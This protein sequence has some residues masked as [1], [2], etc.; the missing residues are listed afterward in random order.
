M[1]YECCWFFS[2]EFGSRS[3]HQY[4]QARQVSDYMGYVKSHFDTTGF[5]N[6]SFSS[7]NPNVISHMANLMVNAMG[8]VNNCNKLYPL[9]KLVVVVPDEDLVKEF[10]NHDGAVSKSIKRILNFIMTEHSRA[11]A[12]F[13]EHLSAKCMRQD[14]PHILWIQPPTHDNFSK[15]SNSLRSK[16]NYC[17][18]EVVKM[19]DN[20]S[21]LMLKKV[22]DGKDN[23]LFL[24]SCNRFTTDGLKSY[25]EAVDRTVHYCDSIALKRSDKSKAQKTS[26]GSGRSCRS[27]DQKDPNCFRWKNPKF[28]NNNQEDFDMEFKKLP[29]PPQ[30]CHIV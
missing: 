23:N 1:A 19:H 13:K 20:V 11:I 27:G 2:D 7:D 16:F 24:S 22:W 6:N 29:P 14:Y 4:F 30:Y 8:T 9:P 21:T 28:N 12:T 5:F 10:F 26:G 15:I 3:F 25:W 17:L 18:E